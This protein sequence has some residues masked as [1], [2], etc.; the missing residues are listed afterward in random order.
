MLNGDI[1]LYDGA[2]YARQKSEITEDKQDSIPL[3]LQKTLTTGV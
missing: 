3:G 2:M 1:E